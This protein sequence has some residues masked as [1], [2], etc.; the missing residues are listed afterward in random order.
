MSQ[1]CVGMRVTTKRN[2]GIQT[3][4][5]VLRVDKKDNS[6]GVMWRIEGGI[7]TQ[8]VPLKNLVQVYEDE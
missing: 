7:M 3:D 2:S 4:G 5:V 1:I 6:A 8:T